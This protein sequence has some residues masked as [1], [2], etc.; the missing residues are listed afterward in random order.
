MIGLRTG[1]AVVVDNDPNDGLMMLSA[2]SKIRI[3]ATYYSGEIGQ[4]PDVPLTGIR[5]AALDMNLGSDGSAE[6]GAMLSPLLS[7]LPHLISKDNGPLV[8]IA[9]TTHPALVTL[10]KERLLTVCPAA[11]PAFVVPLNKSDV[12]D[13]NGNIDINKIVLKLEEAA[14]GWSPLEV[15]H[16]WEQLVHDSASSTCQILSGLATTDDLSKWQPRLEKILK[17]LGKASTGKQKVDGKKFLR[18]IMETLNPVHYDRLEHFTVDIPDNLV[19]TA[20]ALEENTAES[21]VNLAAIESMLLIAPVH[22]SDKSVY[23]GNVYTESKWH[24]SPNNFPVHE[25]RV[26]KGTLIEE[27]FDYPRD[28]KYIELLDEYKKASE[29]STQKR[30]FKIQLK[31]RRTQIHQDIKDACHTVLVDVTPTCDFA[32]QKNPMARLVGGVLIHPS[33]KRLLKPDG[34]TFIRALGPFSI[35][36]P[37]WGPIPPGEYCLV[38]NS[39]YLFGLFQSEIK[40]CAPSA[41]L[42]TQV[43]VDLQSWFAS[44][45]ARPGILSVSS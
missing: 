10:F 26:K 8:I 32:Q 38:L 2:F 23:P 24:P 30:A 39:R 20:K 14:T 41:R 19:N 9:W 7:L 6:D 36:A 28:K 31:D 25:E 11:A 17:S 37:S 12:K 16:F 45:A 21:D 44:H 35:G 3:A 29:G 4:K 15:L 22:D 34:S 33:H 27:M 1:R 40:N 5:I 13:E 18:G 42:R 43:I